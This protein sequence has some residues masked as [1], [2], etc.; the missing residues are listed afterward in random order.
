MLSNELDL[1]QPWWKLALL[2]EARTQRINR[3]ASRPYHHHLIAGLDWHT[4]HEVKKILPAQSKH[5]LNTWVQAAVQ[6]REATKV[7][8]CPLCQVDSTK[9]HPLVMQMAQ[10]TET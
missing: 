4:Y 9:A 5:H 3:L 10:D 6:Y 7:K 1:H 2:Q 8:R